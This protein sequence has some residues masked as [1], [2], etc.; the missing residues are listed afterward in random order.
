M[1]GKGGF[2]TSGFY[3]LVNG[4]CTLYAA[5]VCKPCMVVVMWL[6]HGD[7]LTESA[8][9]VSRKTTRNV[10]KETKNIPIEVDIEAILRILHESC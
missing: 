4:S 1:H 10:L 5:I 6:I 7:L 8:R 9:F 3:V 2:T